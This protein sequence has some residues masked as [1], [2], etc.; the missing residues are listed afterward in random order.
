M[1]YAGVAFSQFTGDPNLGFAS[2]PAA[3]NTTN[4]QF[5]AFLLDNGFPTQNIQQPPDIRPTIGLGNTVSAVSPDDLTLPRFQN[6]SVTF[7]RRLTKNMM[8]D[9]SYIG[10]HGSRLNHSGQRAGLDANMNDPSVLSLGAALLNSN[11]NS[12]AA[13]QANIPIPYAGFNGTVAQALRRYP[14]YQNIDWRGLPLGRSWYNAV[15]LV[16]EQRLSGGLQYRVGYT[17]SKLKNNGAESG[18][19]N[20]GIN[21][22]VQDP[23]NWNTADY[24]LSQDDVPHVLLAGFTWDIASLA[25]NNWTGAKKALLGGWNISGVLRYESGRPLHI[26]MGNDMGGL[27]FN[28]EKRPNRTGTDAVTGGGDFDPLTDNYFNKA[29][30]SDPGPLTFGNAPRADGTVRGFHNYSEDLTLSKNFH[31]K[32]DM[33]MRFVAEVGNIFNRTTFC[34]PNTDFSSP[35]FGTVNTQCNQARSVQ[36][37]LRLDY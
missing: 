32:G 17:Y 35:A 25:A 36:F 27:L 24:G 15:E 21:G 2:N 18:Q 9:V 11:I 6:W 20:E 1:Y 13:R 16:L 22:G 34:N 5:P 31:L 4:G 30:W 28:T 10:N 14:Q 19:G 23:V 7:E 37:G 26:T 3:P 29:G 33:K 12:P 8:L